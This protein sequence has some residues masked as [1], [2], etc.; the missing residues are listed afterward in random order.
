LKGKERKKQYPKRPQIIFIPD[1]TARYRARLPTDQCTPFTNDICC[2][3]R[4]VRSATAS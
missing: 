4:C 2:N 3:K 1:P